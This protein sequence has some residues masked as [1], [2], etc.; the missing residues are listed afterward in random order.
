MSKFFVYLTK[1]GAHAGIS[2]RP[3]GLTF[4]PSLHELSMFWVC[5]MRA[6][7]HLAN[8]SIM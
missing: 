7:K 2:S 4:V 6:A 5:D 1:P 3:S 8:L